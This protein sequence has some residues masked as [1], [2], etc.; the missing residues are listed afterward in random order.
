MDKHDDDVGVSRV[1]E[2]SGNATVLVAGE[3][4]DEEKLGCGGDESGELMVGLVGSDVFFDGVSG[5]GVGGNGELGVQGD[6]FVDDQGRGDGVEELGEIAGSSG[7]KVFEGDGV[8]SEDVVMEEVGIVAKEVVVEENVKVAVSESGLERGEELTE[9]EGVSC[10]STVPFP[11]EDSDMHGD[12]MNCDTKVVE[13]DVKVVMNEDSKNYGEVTESDRVSCELATLSAHEDSDMHGDAMKSNTKVVEEDVKVVVDEDS[14]KCGEVTERD[15]V[16]CELATLTDLDGSDMH[17]D[18]MKCDTKVAKEDVKVVVDEDSLKYVEVTERDGVSC[19]MAISSAGED[20]NMHSYVIEED[21]KVAANEESL[22]RGEIVIERD[23]VSC[24][25]ATTSAEEDS[26]IPREAVNGA[27]EVG[28]GETLVVTESSSV[29]THIAEELDSV[30]NEDRAEAV[31]SSVEVLENQLMKP[32]IGVLGDEASDAH[33]L[34]DIVSSDKSVGTAKRTGLIEGVIEEDMKVPGSESGLKRDEEVTVRGDVSS[35]LATPSACE[36]GHMHGD[37]MDSDTKVAEEDVE[38]VTNENSRKCEEVTER[39]AGSC[40]LTVTSSCENTD[41]QVDTMNCSSKVIDENPKIAPIE[42][43][44]GRGENVIDRDDVS[45]GLES[46]IHAVAENGTDEVSAGDKLLVTGSYNADTSGAAETLTSVA[47][48]DGAEEAV[49]PLGKALE[50][51]M[52]PNIGLLGNEATDAHVLDDMDTS[53]RSGETAMR[54]GLIEGEFDIDEGTQTSIDLVST[55]ERSGIVAGV[56]EAIDDKILN[57]DGDVKFGDHKFLTTASEEILVENAECRRE[58]EL[59]AEPLHGSSRSD[60]AVCSDP[61]SGGKQILADTQLILNDSLLVNPIANIDRHETICSDT[62]K[63]VEQFDILGTNVSGDGFK[64]A[65][66]S[67]EN[68]SVADASNHTL[69]GCIEGVMAGNNS[70]IDVGIHTYPISSSQENHDTEATMMSINVADSNMEVSTTAMD[71]IFGSEDIRGLKFDPSRKDGD[72]PINEEKINKHVTDCIDSGVQETE[73]DSDL[74]IPKFL[75]AT[76]TGNF[77]EGTS[78]QDHILEVEEEYNDENQADASKMEETD[79]LDKAMDFEQSDA[80][81]EKFPEQMSPGDG[82]LFSDCHSHYL[83]PPENEGEFS[84]SD[85]VW[86]KV[87]SHPWWPG[88]I[89]N[90]S[91]ASEKAMKHHKKDCFLVSYFGDRTFAWNDASWLRPFRTHFSLIKEQSNSEA[92]QHAVSCALAEVSRRVELG[93]ACSCIPKKSLAGI[94]SQSLENAGIH[95]EAAI[96]YGVDESSA[97]SCFEPKELLEHIRSLAVLPAAGSDVL[98]QLVISKAQLSAFSRFKGQCPLPEFQSYGGLLEKDANTD[99]I[100]Q[101]VNQ[102]ISEN[103]FSSKRSHDFVDSLPPRK[104]ERS[105]SD[106]IEDKPHSSDVDDEFNSNITDKSFATSAGIKRKAQN[107]LTEGS[108]K[109]QSYYAAKVST[110]AS[111]SPKPSFKIGECIRRAASQLTASPSLVKS[112]SEKFLKVDDSVGQHLGLDDTSQIP[113]NSQKER[114][115][116][117]PEHSSLAETLSQLHL[118]AQDPIKGYSFLKNITTFFTGFRHSVAS[119][120]NSRMRNLSTGRGGRKKKAPQSILNSPEEFEFD[121]VNDSYWTDRI[122]QNY[123]EDELLNNAQ[124][125][126]AD[127]QLLLHQADKPVKSSRRSRKQFSNGEHLVVAEEP[128][129]EQIDKKQDCSPTELILNFSEG[130]SLPTELN[131]NKILRRFGPLR[132]CETEVDRE[133]RRARVVYKRSS[134]AEVALSSAGNFNI[135]GPMHVKY[136]LSYVPSAPYK[137]LPVAALEGELNA[138]SFI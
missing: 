131:L 137:P 13:E 57:S 15:C 48:E 6:G 50:N 87:R 105:M 133:T 102:I 113:V 76:S 7:D 49:K 29:S 132:E 4:L 70:E 71:A 53:D 43:A 30:V 1:S 62:G 106:L 111:Q 33:V 42:N 104:K 80:F 94:E 127:Y 110:T 10:E 100:Q 28:A 44:F 64:E 86:G 5:V 75:D 40:K 14:K 9:R 38:V 60:I 21:V 59:K 107:S 63:N 26:S 90:P 12:A 115:M 122:V 61:E 130:H 134:D 22:G 35:V 31:K 2:S 125:G 79:G 32:V 120:Q 91:D 98:L 69:S 84:A 121:D 89:C 118:A 85:L 16:T 23:E 3:T 119:G 135:F 124:N 47:N 109:R 34:Y 56:T 37:A 93:L 18:A 103:N 51:Q 99:G 67:K 128:I 123:G 8:V 72:V 112:N 45:W 108:D 116:L 24:K 138:S 83:L 73:G 27:D 114:T 77:V 46:G 101:H 65:I 19:E 81:D 129:A 68:G 55:I 25:L 88:Q 20:I 117:S 96:R 17:G 66:D 78:G 36:D 74:P 92:F 82:S 41:I 126:E 54:T 52:M 136:E 11:C 58:K 39:N 95:Q 97:A